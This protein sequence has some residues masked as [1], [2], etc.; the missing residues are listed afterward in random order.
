MLGP[1]GFHA[2]VAPLPN[3]SNNPA[4]P[5]S[6][7]PDTLGLMKQLINSAGKP[8]NYDPVYNNIYEDKTLAEFKAQAGENSEESTLYFRTHASQYVMQFVQECKVYRHGVFQSTF[9]D[10]V[11]NYHMLNQINSQVKREYTATLNG[12]IDLMDTVAL[13]TSIWFGFIVSGILKNS[14]SASPSRQ[15]ILQAVQNAAINILNIEIV[16]WLHGSHKGKQYLYNPTPEIADLLNNFNRRRQAAEAVWQFFEENS[17]YSTANFM[18]NKS[19]EGSAQSILPEVAMVN[20][21]QRITTP[22]GMGTQAL[23]GSFIPDFSETTT[24]EQRELMM[25]PFNNLR[26]RSK[27]SDINTPPPVRQTPDMYSDYDGY[28]SPSA[29]FRT[30]IVNITPGNRNLF[31]VRSF[32]QKTG[33]PNWW[34]VEEDDWIFIRGALKRSP[35]QRMEE[36]LVKHCKRL[37]QYDFDDESAGWTSRS[38]RFK[39]IDATMILSDPEKLLPLLTD[40]GFD[41]DTAVKVMDAKQFFDEEGKKFGPNAEVFDEL[42]E[43]GF[44][45]RIIKS[46]EK[47]ENENTAKIME[48]L[49]V[50]GHAMTQETNQPTAIF[51]D[52]DVLGRTLFSDK[53]KRDAIEKRFPMF[54]HGND[55]LEDHSYFSAIQEIKKSFQRG[56]IDGPEIETQDRFDVFVERR[57]TTDINNWLINAC[58]Y[59]VKKEDGQQLNVDNIFEDVEE[60]KKVLLVQD[61]EAYDALNQ[62]GRSCILLEQMKLFDPI[63]DTPEEL[64]AIE[65]TEYE[66][67]LFRRKKYSG[68]IICNQSGPKPPRDKTIILRRSVHPEF[69]LLL[70]QLRKDLPLKGRSLDSENIM[71]MYK[72]SND[73]FMV[74]QTIY[75]EN[76]VS[77]RTIV[78]RRTL[79][80]PAY[81]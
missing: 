64:S 29:R 60:L 78:P 62:L 2:K 79:L 75:D 25:I 41:P 33:L 45:Y 46:E 28:G 52:F 22:N 23:D 51:N 13:R 77:I 3:T 9:K 17:P 16:L 49:H 59:A 19:M 39:G 70:D 8:Q 12:R 44:D 1:S 54:F 81:G 43:A 18:D 27:Y 10:L 26:A 65:K 36:T 76:V 40:P 56:Q 67:S 47:L 42:R 30:D 58:G 7:V 34:V 14:Q 50:M 11:E 48:R 63:V 68:V 31:D 53:Q 71:F 69:F 35:K 21:R 37:V 24:D 32:F 72:N 80:N 61:K 4:Q 15:Q 57:L 38:I 73:L 66:M 55:F 5:Q 6:G 20:A 74:T